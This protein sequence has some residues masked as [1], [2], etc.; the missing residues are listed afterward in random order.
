MFHAQDANTQHTVGRYTLLLLRSSADNPI[1]HCHRCAKAG[2]VVRT[3]ITER[4]ALGSL[5]ELRRAAI[6]VLLYRRLASPSDERDQALPPQALTHS[7]LFYSGLCHSTAGSTPPPE[8]SSFL[9]PVLS[10]S[11]PLPF[12]LQCHLSNDVL[13]FQLI[14]HL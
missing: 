12:A 8:S 13:V 2:H 9:C 5:E 4:Q 7:N 3:A 6:F 1:S 10:L 14:L 11:I